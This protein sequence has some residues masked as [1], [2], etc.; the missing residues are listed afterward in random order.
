MRTHYGTKRAT[1]L[2]VDDTPSNLSLISDLLKD[3]YQVKVATCGLRA[4]EI[5]RSP[6]KPDLILL[7]V[8]M[9]DIDGYAVCRELK[10]NTGTEHIPIIF[11]TA[12][13]DPADEERG[14]MLGAVDYITKPIS[15]PVVLA[16]IKTQLQLQ[17]YS[18]R[19]QMLV[20]MHTAELSYTRNRFE[21]LH[22][23]SM[24]L[25]RA[26]DYQAMLGIALEGGL[27]I[28]NCDAATFFVRTDHNTLELAAHTQA[29]TSLIAQIP[30]YNHGTGTPN[31]LDACAHSLHLRKIMVIDDVSQESRFD[32][33]G[34]RELDSMANYKTV[35]VLVVPVIPVSG[36]V[37]GV[38]CFHNARGPQ[39]GPFV[40]FDTRDVAYVQAH[41]AQTA[42]A[43][44]RA[45]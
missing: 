45:S 5:A 43:L 27:A 6:V 9:P 39:P 38:L 10:S 2:V 23:A 33:T 7:D 41:A 30:L 19:L 25:V 32:T 18:A 24:E 15:P 20:D 12:R 29:T 44:S 17:A 16:R 11:L 40:P 34:I 1:I 22:E 3:T 13:A 28:L 8:L 4:L 26:T 42:A 31:T 35:S 36:E 14:L 21:V 37:M